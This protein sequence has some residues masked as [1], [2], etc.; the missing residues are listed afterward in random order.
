LSLTQAVAARSETGEATAPV[1]PR[2]RAPAKR[3]I[4]TRARALNAALGP[5]SHRKTKRLVFSGL[6]QCHRHAL[7]RGLRLML[8]AWGPVGVGLATALAQGAAQTGQLMPDQQAIV[9]KIAKPD[10]LPDAR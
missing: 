7:S 4:F 8:A 6:Y 2:Y 9:D 10:A 5:F 1:F 3:P